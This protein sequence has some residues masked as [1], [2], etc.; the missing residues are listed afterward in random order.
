MTLSV[1]FVC[2][3]FV[4][5]YLT[6]C[7]DGRTFSNPTVSKVQKSSPAE[8]AQAISRFVNHVTL[9]GYERFSKAVTEAEKLEHEVGQLMSEPKDSTLKQARRQWRH[10][11]NTYL[12]AQI[13]FYLPIKDPIE[14]QQQ[15][16]GYKDLFNNIDSFPIEGGYLD[17]MQGYPFSGLVNDLTLKM[18]A[19]TIVEQHQ[20]ADPSYASLGF[21][22]LEFLLWGENG[23]RLS[24][25]YYKQ[26]NQ[27]AILANNENAKGGIQNNLRR[28]TLLRLVSERLVK[29]LR[30]IKQRWELSNGFYANMF[31]ENKPHRVL[32]VILQAHQRLLEQDLLAKRLSLGSSEFSKSTAQDVLALIQ[33]VIKLYFLTENNLETLAL[34]NKN[35]RLAADWQEMNKQLLAAI[36]TWQHSKKSQDKEQVSKRVIEALQLLSQVA[37][38]FDIKLPKKK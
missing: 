8:Q 2:V 37:K 7:E 23:T 9:N 14:W 29:D 1:R 31:T 3:F 28:R 17:Y 21:H 27:H 26:K 19:S 34:L 6:A 11:Y 13:Y 32:G 16:I 20:L 30:H 25:D 22:V 15:H 24:R 10:T 18:N 4:G 33:G 38:A 5:L 12:S 35:P 36:K